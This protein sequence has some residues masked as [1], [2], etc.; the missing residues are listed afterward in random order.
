MGVKAAVEEDGGR[1]PKL[2]LGVSDSTGSGGNLSH[3]CPSFYTAINYLGL[4]ISELLMRSLLKG[5]LSHSFKWGV[6]HGTLH[7]CKREGERERWRTNGLPSL[8]S[9]HSFL[10]FAMFFRACHIA[11]NKLSVIFK[12]S[13]CSFIALVIYL[14]CVSLVKGS[15]GAKV[16]LYQSV[17]VFLWLQ[18]WIRILLKYYV[19]LGF[20]PTDLSTFLLDR[21]KGY[22]FCI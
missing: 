17:H 4:L 2:D 11:I 22:E 12:L 16:V 3:P 19:I 6:R 18:S 9:H 14:K 7:A 8:R 1:V 20:N 13:R 21:K 10:T 15:S 5:Q